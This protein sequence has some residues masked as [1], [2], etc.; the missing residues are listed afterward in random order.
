MKKLMNENPMKI[1]LE[2]LFIDYNLDFGMFTNLNDRLLEIEDKYKMLTKPDKIIL[3]LYAELGSFRKVG[4]FLG[5]SHS[6]IRNKINE[7]RLKLC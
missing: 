4:D 6:T 2:G 5:F 7:I 1:N 3:I